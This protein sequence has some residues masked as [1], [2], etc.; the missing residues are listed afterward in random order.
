[1]EL[2]FSCSPAMK[3]HLIRLVECQKIVVPVALNMLLTLACWVG[4]Y[5]MKVDEQ[6]V[7]MLFGNSGHTLSEAL[8]NGFC[9]ALMLVCVAFLMLAFAMYDMRRLVQFWLYSS[10][11][12]LLFMVSFNFF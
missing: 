6:L 4:V 10:C 12:L 7:E 9:S 8:V 1:M 5:E 11:V 3:K 2:S